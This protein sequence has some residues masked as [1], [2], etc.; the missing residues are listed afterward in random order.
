[1]LTT[2]HTSVIISVLARAHAQTSECTTWKT[3]WLHCDINRWLNLS[4]KS[5]K[6]EL[7]CLRKGSVSYGLGA[8]FSLPHCLVGDRVSESNLEP[9]PAGISDLRAEISWCIVM[10]RRSGKASRRYRCQLY[11]SLV[12]SSFSLFFFFCLIHAMWKTQWLHFY[13]RMI[14][15]ILRLASHPKGSI[16]LLQIRF[17]LFIRL[18]NA[19]VENVE[20]LRSVQKTFDP[21]M[22]VPASK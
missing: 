7:R 12:F 11:F 4:L 19:A 21:G 6:V 9:S 1:M 10:V 16:F 17:V 22:E 2:G 13:N 20:K 3:R 14:T 5:S 8:D 15:W 18:I